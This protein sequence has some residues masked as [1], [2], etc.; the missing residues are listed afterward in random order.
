MSTVISNARQI[1]LVLKFIPTIL[2]EHAEISR[3]QNKNTSRTGQVVL[4][5]ALVEWVVE[6]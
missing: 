5:F 6:R 4:C 3:M 2:I 1:K